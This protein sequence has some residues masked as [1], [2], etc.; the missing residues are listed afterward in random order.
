VSNVNPKDDPL[1]PEE[2]ADDDFARLLAILIRRRWWVLGATTL[3]LLAAA[4]TIW[5]M[6][7]IYRSTTVAFPASHKGSLGGIGNVLSQVSGVAS[8]AGLDVGDSG[9]PEAVAILNSRQFNERFILANALMPILFDK[10]WDAS[11]NDWKPHLLRPRT[12]WDGYDY[13][14]RKVRTVSE[15]R[16]SG[17]LT[18]NID[19]SNRDQAAQWANKILAQLNQEMRQRA[20]DEA[21]A[22][23]S[24]LNKELDKADNLSLKEAI[25][26]LIE[27][28][29]KER[30]LAT[31]RYEYGYHVIDAAE[32]ADPRHP[33]KPQMR[34]YLVF[35]AIG[36][37]I[38]G[39]LAALLDQSI[40]GNKA[41]TGKKP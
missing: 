13:F 23:V 8:M 38:L 24:Y 41:T 22:M 19:W 14:V 20:I 37:L 5:L 29:I 3:G 15:D 32:P 17:L 31:V 39:I 12:L 16:K 34:V 4:L 9:N 25:S 21:T 33:S 30:A 40:N 36:G 1:A 10:D 2:H 18:I 26:K 35:G 11:R 28:E 6:T 27:S 7:P